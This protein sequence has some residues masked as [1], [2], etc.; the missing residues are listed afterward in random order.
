MCSPWAARRSAPACLGAP[1]AP[2]PRLSLG[3]LV[4]LAS[5]VVG[6]VLVAWPLSLIWPPI[7]PSG[8]EKQAESPHHHSGVLLLSDCIR[9]SIELGRRCSS[10]RAAWRRFPSAVAPL[11]HTERAAASSSIW[12]RASR[13]TS[14]SSR[15]IRKREPAAVRLASFDEC[16]LQLGVSLL[17]ITAPKSQRGSDSLSSERAR[18]RSREWDSR[19]VA[20][21]SA[22]WRSGG[23]TGP[24]DVETP[25]ALRAAARG[26][27]PWMVL[28]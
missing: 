23:A 21:R 25:E 17:L 8:G 3:R 28:V 12:R 20:A 15:H 18:S 9:E 13:T 26:D 22:R 4:A 1:P 16:R 24:W 10:R 6:E 11:R 7:A 2:A 5:S 14:A 19:R 27:A